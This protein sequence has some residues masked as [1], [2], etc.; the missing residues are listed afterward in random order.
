MATPGFNFKPD[1]PFVVTS[2]SYDFSTS[3]SSLYAQVHYQVGP[4][5]GALAINGVNI[6][7]LTTTASHILNDVQWMPGGTTFSVTGSCRVALSL[8]DEDA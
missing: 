6:A 8:Y 3:T 2:G 5:S 4:G 1:S 7:N